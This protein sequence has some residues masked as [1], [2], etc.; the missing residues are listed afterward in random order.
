M[1]GCVVL[2]CTLPPHGAVGGMAVLVVGLLGRAVVVR[3]RA[4]TR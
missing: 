3:R 4:A 2:A 1:V